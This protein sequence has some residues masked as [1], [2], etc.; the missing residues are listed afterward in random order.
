MI[1]EK[2]RAITNE[3]KNTHLIFFTNQ[4]NN[5]K[6]NIKNKNKKKT[7]IDFNDKIMGFFFRCLTQFTKF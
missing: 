6:L 2:K 3:N 1:A 7:A 5:I 4:K